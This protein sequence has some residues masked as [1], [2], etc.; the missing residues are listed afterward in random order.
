[1]NPSQLEAKFSMSYD[2]SMKSYFS[3]FDFCTVHQYLCKVWGIKYKVL[4]KKK[5]FFMILTHSY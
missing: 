4:G 3:D 5:V 1:M 2:H